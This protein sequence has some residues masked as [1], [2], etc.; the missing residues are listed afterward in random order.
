METPVIT[1][2]FQTE[3]GERITAVSVGCGRGYLALKRAVDIMIALSGLLF[4]AVPM[5]IVA[6]IIRIDS[7]GPAIF[8]Q[9]RM[10]RNAQQFTIYK[11]R[12]M[13][14]DAPSQM[15]SREFT[16]SDQF[17]TK[18]GKFLRR[19]SIDELPQ[20]IN[21]LKGDMSL[22]GYRP[23][24]LTEE[25]LNTLRKQYGVFALRPGV[26]GLAQVSGRDN[27][28]GEKKAQLDAQYVS[29]CSAKMDLMCIWKT[30]KTVLSGEG[31]F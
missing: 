4:L 8:K 27:V 15:A 5:L 25:R 13:K 1:N 28:Y 16:D 9:Q 26:T 3:Q 14:M 18:F 20:L 11:F 6:V 29:Q 22:V 30:I 2:D 19:T 17:I 7:S 31:V 24:C 21:I 12:T 23:V 10:G